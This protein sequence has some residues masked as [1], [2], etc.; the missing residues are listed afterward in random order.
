MTISWPVEMIFIVSAVSLYSIFLL[1]PGC[2]A[3]AC[4]DLLILLH[5]HY[6]R[7]NYIVVVLV[8]FYLAAVLITNVKPYSSL[9]VS[10]L[11]M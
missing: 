10:V 4:A 2:A 8:T 3:V 6:N 9:N 7:I 1:T 11:M 5:T